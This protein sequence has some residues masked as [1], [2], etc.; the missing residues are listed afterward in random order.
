MPATGCPQEPALQADANGGAQN[1]IINVI[2]FLVFVALFYAD[3]AA[4]QARVQQR[5]QL[6]QAQ[7]RSGDREVFLD[8]QGQ[9]VSRLKEVRGGLCSFCT[10]IFSCSSGVMWVR[11]G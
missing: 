10:A 7:I 2:G 5:R 6:R 3:Q 9:K 1:L 8:D 11:C 4:G